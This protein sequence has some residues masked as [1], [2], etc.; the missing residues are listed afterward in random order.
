[1]GLGCKAFFPKA[2]P[3]A[4]GVEVWAP[5]LRTP[6]VI[7]ETPFSRLEVDPARTTS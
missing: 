3:G 1:M 6:E 2:E 5:C 7:L 4:Q